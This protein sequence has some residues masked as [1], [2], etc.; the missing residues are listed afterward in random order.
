MTTI[1]TDDDVIQDSEDEHSFAR[2]TIEVNPTNMRPSQSPGQQPAMATTSASTIQTTD[3]TPQPRTRDSRQGPGDGYSDI[4]TFPLTTNPVAST[5]VSI[6]S[7]TGPKSGKTRPRP[8]PVYK[9]AAAAK[10]VT[11]TDPSSSIR[12]PS[13]PNA[14]GSHA[15]ESTKNSKEKTAT[16]PEHILEPFS[17]DIAERAKLRSRA[18]TSTAASKQRAYSEFVADVIDLSSDDEFNL[19]PPVRVPKSRSNV[20]VKTT[21]AKRRVDASRIHDL[22]PELPSGTLPIA[23]SDIS[24]NVDMSSQLPP[25]DPPP[26]STSTLPP[27]TPPTLS[28]AP[29]PPRDR[30][31]SPLSSPPPVPVRKRKRSMQ[32]AVRN[33]EGTN[34]SPRMQEQI[35]SSTAMPPPP[36]PP[37]FA[38]SSSSEAAIPETLVDVAPS[39]VAPSLAVSGVTKKG[40]SSKGKKKPVDDDFEDFEDGGWVDIPKP[41]PK[42]RPRKKAGQDDDA[43]W[44][45]QEA[46]KGRKSR[47]KAKGSD[48]EDEDEDE[49]PAK[50]KPKPK[51]KPAP[52]KR[53]RKGTA[54]KSKVMEVVIDDS[55]S[56]ANTKRATRGDS[57]AKPPT[58]REIVDDSDGELCPLVLPPGTPPRT[59]EGLVTFTRTS[60][61]EDQWNDGPASLP[62]TSIPFPTRGAAPDG[63][64]DISPRLSTKSKGKKRAVVISDDEDFD[65]AVSTPGSP[66]KKVRREPRA[67]KK[68]APAALERDS[69]AEEEEDISTKENVYPSSV[70]MSTPFKQPNPPSSATKHPSS[71]RAYSI[72]SGKSTPMSE[73]IRRVNSLPGSPFPAAKP[74]YSPFSKSSKSLLKR[75]A[76]LH[77][78]RRTPPPPPP[79]PPPPKKSKKQLE[80][81][82]KWEMELEESVEGWY[83]LSEEE[84][85]ALRRAKRDAEMGFE[86]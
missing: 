4:S 8:R 75:I 81:E 63:T 36:P 39:P 74:I 28:H 57:T 38:G 22:E 54:R 77:P 66:P 14:M 25:S 56:K 41:K 80:L 82:E 51:P 18:R 84:R 50:P 61:R 55:P 67:P 17:L 26:P 46:L 52:K 7:A 29:Q 31:S 62:P 30:L 78:N 33:D 43:D 11:I 10:D 83:C 53:G 69:E 48:E 79:R 64:E 1:V 58:S 27:S 86:D 5:I 59:G 42:A 23:T 9:G 44:D 70:S 20:K 3:F 35:S 40:A 49:W 32:A 2:D 85:A 47:K 21:A 34:L 12:A 76:P 19:R 71:N 37:F 73:L 45:G 6:S 13:S 65:A 60:R 72:S 15:R 24:F 68:S 16:L